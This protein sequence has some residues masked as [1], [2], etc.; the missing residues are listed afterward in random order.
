MAASMAVAL[1]ALFSI[2]TC[3]MVVTISQLIVTDFYKSC[4]DPKAWW[5][6]TA[7]ANYC[8]YIVIVTIW[9]FYKESSWIKTLFFPVAMFFLGS[10]ISC[11]YIA[12]QFFKLS[13]AESSK[14]PVFF[15]LARHQKGDVVGHTRRHSLVIAKVIV[16]ALGC[17]MLGFLIHAIIVDGSP[18]HAQMLTPCMRCTLIDTLIEIVVF[19]VWIAYKE[20]SWTSAIV[21][22]LLSQC[23]GSIGL[24]VYLL[25]E[26]NRLSP[27]QHISLILF[28]QSD[29]DLM[30][31]DPL[32]TQHSNV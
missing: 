26:L 16:A 12:M 7:I 25:R 22:I 23:S 32:L 14:N 6:M 18:F 31:S 5:M 28:S 20:S 24:C 3:V 27:Q 17:F 1:K 29:R 30:S 4:V 13:P 15:V 10:I 9:F 11:G 8:V 2:L 19:S 21:W